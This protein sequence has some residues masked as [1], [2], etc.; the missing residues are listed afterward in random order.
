MLN[1]NWIIFGAIL[2]LVGIS[3]YIFDTLKGKNKPHKI[4]WGIWA[5]APLI[6]FYAELQ[7]GVGLQSLMTF[8]AGFGP[9][10]VFIASFFNKNAYW[11]IKGFDLACGGFAII[12]L[13][14]V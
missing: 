1:E 11:K 6:A 3:S 10:L 13:I 5:I 14:L 9:L 7:E 2:S 8:V 12:G 4:S